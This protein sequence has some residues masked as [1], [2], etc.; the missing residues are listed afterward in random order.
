MSNISLSI[1]IVK[2]IKELYDSAETIQE[3]KQ[4]AEKAKNGLQPFPP[5][6]K[7]QKL[8]DGNV[9]IKKTLDSIVRLGIPEASEQKVSLQTLFNPKTKHQALEKLNKSFEVRERY[10]RSMKNY[11]VNIR[12]LT[13]E[14]QAK[15]GGAKELS[16]FAYKIA[17]QF[18][19]VSAISLPAYKHSQDFSKLRGSLNQ[20]VSAGTKA[21]QRLE[22]DLKVYEEATKRLD[23]NLKMFQLKRSNSTLY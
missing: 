4:A 16:D 2:A 1:E 7:I 14:A 17:A 21:I 18:I 11:I 23:S 15:A 10:I 20:I 3:Y 8:L 13:K 19:A 9:Q 12:K 22:R 6:E 5:H